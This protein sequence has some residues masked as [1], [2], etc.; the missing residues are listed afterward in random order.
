MGLSERFLLLSMLYLIFPYFARCGTIPSQRHVRNHTQTSPETRHRDA[1]QEEQ[2]MA[3]GSRQFDLRTRQGSRLLRHHHWR[4]CRSDCGKRKFDIRRGS[5]H[6]FRYPSPCP[7]R[8]NRWVRR[9]DTSLLFS[10][11]YFCFTRLHKGIN[12]SFI[13]SGKLYIN[14]FFN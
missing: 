13:S 14:L 11:F 6:L 3:N 1:H 2:R 4:T 7:N 8:G 10:L 5:I 9:L 12:P